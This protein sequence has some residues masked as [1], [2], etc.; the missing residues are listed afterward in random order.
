MAKEEYTEF[1]RLIS[2]SQ[3]SMIFVLELSFTIYLDK[4][5]IA[6]LKKEVM[7]L[8]MKTNL[9]VVLFALTIM[10]GVTN[11]YAISI[12]CPPINCEGCPGL[13]PGF[14][15]H[16]I[17]VYL[18]LTKGAYSAAYDTKMDDIAME[19]LLS[20]IQGGGFPQATFEN[21]L[22]AL[23]AKG[24]GSEV[25]RTNAANWLNWAAGYVPFED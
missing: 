6:R 9:L 19:N 3:L 23:Q 18:G 21:L 20:L 14:W 12:P 4:V 8:K 7:N 16:N 5:E 13:T 22:E 1:G 11:V 17:Q 15:K 24:P 2:K 25:I 10:L